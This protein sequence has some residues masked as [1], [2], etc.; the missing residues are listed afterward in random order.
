MVL[1]LALTD[2]LLR[3][4]MPLYELFSETIYK[5][6]VKTKT[7]QKNIDLINASDFF[8]VLFK[9]GIKTDS[10]NHDNLMKFLCLDVNFVDKIYVKKL[11]KAIEEFAVNDELRVVAHK[12]YQELVQSDGDEDDPEINQEE[13]N[14]NLMDSPEDQQYPEK[15]QYFSLFLL[16]IYLETRLMMKSMKLMQIQKAVMQKSA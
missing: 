14:P 7:R 4:K 3:T 13:H 2:Y 15:Q 1:M 6:V 10:S 16:L 5:Q 8:D 12:C 11:K 9:L